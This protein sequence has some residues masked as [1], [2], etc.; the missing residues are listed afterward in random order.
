M[1]IVKAKVMR[2]CELY[3]IPAEQ[4]VPCDV[5]AIEACDIVPADGRLLRLLT[6]EV[7]ESALTGEPARL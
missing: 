1:M 4:L 2:Y 6:L 7:A 3:E 5:V